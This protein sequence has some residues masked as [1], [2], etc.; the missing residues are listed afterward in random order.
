[1][2]R[3]SPLSTGFAASKRK[4][5]RSTTN[6]DSYGS[7]SSTS[8]KKSR[9]STSCTLFGSAFSPTQSGKT[10][11]VA[12][13][14]NGLICVWDSTGASTEPIIRVEATA[15]DKVLYD[16]QFIESSGDTLLV[17][18]GD[19]GILLYKW[20]AFLNAMDNLIDGNVV[21]EPIAKFKP[22]PSP[23][24]AFG[25]PVEINCTSYSAVD[26]MLYG[27]AGDAFGCYQWD[28]RSEKL[29]GTFGGAGNNRCSGDY[30]HDVLSIPNNNHLV[31][32]AGEDG[33]I[34]FWDGKERK[35]IETMN[36]Q[37]TMNTNK[38]YVSWQ[39]Q[40]K[41]FGSTQQWSSGS[42]L[43]VSSMDNKGD[44]LAAVGGS[45]SGNNMSLRSGPNTAGFMATWH[46]PTRTFNSGSVTRE[47]YNAITY[48]QNL[49]S[50]V[51]GGNN[52][53]LTFWDSATGE[54]T[55]RSGC[56]PSMIYTLSCNTVPSMIVAG[57]TGGSL[58]CFIDR[59]KASNFTT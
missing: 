50:F 44:W 21:L 57:G 24:D 14:S 13:T 8:C 34:T 7:R 41:G 47:S 19:P 59:V 5:F 3:L 1:M 43:W 42:N 58:D 39:V 32:T 23:S 56:T 28:L 31:L 49:D 2:I 35:L 9:L 33:A 54:C 25:E 45:E 26:N 38:Q 18:S 20:S 12:C 22:H 15:A 37:N 53:R 17:V 51:S 29:V 11:L 48:N 27:G 55:G 46:L 4:F 40:N 16:V 52:G 30:L 10:Y 36:V 6:E